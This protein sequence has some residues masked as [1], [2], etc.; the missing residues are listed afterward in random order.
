[1]VATTTETVSSKKPTHREW[2]LNGKVLVSRRESE[3]S[4][5]PGQS[6]QTDETEG[7]EQ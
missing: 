3:N 4:T 7:G 6:G 5:S 2:A 1:M